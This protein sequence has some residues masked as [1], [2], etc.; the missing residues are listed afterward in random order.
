[1]FVHLFVANAPARLYVQTRYNNKN[2]INNANSMWPIDVSWY[3]P[4]HDRAHDRVH[5]YRT[6]KECWL[7]MYIQTYIWT[8]MNLDNGYI[9]RCGTEQVFCMCLFIWVKSIEKWV[10]ILQKK[11]AWIFDLDVLIPIQ[12]D[13]IIVSNTF[14]NYFSNRNKCIFFSI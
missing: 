6:G 3:I 7:N 2:V 9:V 4:I 8:H 12:F 11:A 13:P 14:W 1:M 5:Y 10:T